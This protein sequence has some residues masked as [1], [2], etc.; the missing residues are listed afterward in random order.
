MRQVF[1][2]SYFF[3]PLGLAGVQR[4]LKFIKYLPSYG[5]RATVLTVKEVDW[6]VRDRTLLDEVP[7]DVEVIRTESLEPF[8]LTHLLLPRRGSG[9]SQ[10]QFLLRRGPFPYLNDFL[11][12]PD[13]KVGWVPAALGQ[14]RRAA[15]ADHFDLIYSTAPPYSAHLLAS[16]LKLHTGLPMV[17]DFRDSWSDNPFTR[18]PTPFHRALVSYLE[19]RTLRRADVV[20]AVDRAIAGLLARKLR[21]E[22]RSKVRVVEQGY[23][24]EDFMVRPA[25]RDRRFTI[26]YTGTFIGDR[27]CRY[28]LT[29]LSHLIVQGRI[30]RD[31]VR[32]C[33][34]GARARSEESVATR[35]GLDEVVEF[36]PYVPHRDSVSYLMSADLLWLIIGPDEGETIATGTLYEYI[37]A[38]RPILASVPRGMAQ[39]LIESTGA[40]IAVHPRDVPGLERVLLQLYRNYKQDRQLP[41][42]P[43]EVAARFDRRYLTG[44]LAAIFDEAVRGRGRA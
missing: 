20:V 13:G 4:T 8:R 36:I 1:I 26:V 21:P 41:E 10:A 23:D 19:R 43:R 32:V 34:V 15:L 14:A 42:I 11:F 29:A 28:L 37:G 16:L 31:D 5:W 6:F 17:I 24:P 12:V 38:R 7:E 30:P 9:V 25:P 44:K 27:T 40:G 22:E 3:P 2:I 39:E 33:F 18:R 35:L